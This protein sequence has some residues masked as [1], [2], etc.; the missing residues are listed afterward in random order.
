MHT[1][2][3]RSRKLLCRGNSAGPF[4]WFL[5]QRCTIDD[6]VGRSCIAAEGEKRQ[7]LMGRGRHPRQG[8]TR[9]TITRHECPS[10]QGARFRVV[11]TGRLQAPQIGVSSSDVGIGSA[12]GMITAV[13]LWRTCCLTTLSPCPRLSAGPRSWPLGV[14]GRQLINRQF[15]RHIDQHQHVQWMAVSR[16]RPRPRPTICCNSSTVIRRRNASAISSGWQ[17]RSVETSRPSTSSCTASM[18]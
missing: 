7:G 12:V 4:I 6:G 15:E 18:R 3:W 13:K 11:S 14:V 5:L 8:T 17:S 16:Q 2:S 9:L 10:V 1:G